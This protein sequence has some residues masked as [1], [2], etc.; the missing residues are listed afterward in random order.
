MVDDDIQK[1]IFNPARAGEMEKGFISTNIIPSGSG[2]NFSL[3]GLTKSNWFF[4]LGGNLE[5]EKSD[6]NDFEYF[7]DNSRTT[8]ENGERFETNYDRYRSKF[9]NKSDS[10]A[11]DITISKIFSTVSGW[12]YSVGLF[13][14]YL[15]WEYRRLR[16]N[17]NYSRESSYTERDTLFESRIREVY[18][19]GIDKRIQKDE[20]IVFGV[21]FSTFKSG[22]DS[23]HRI[24]VQKSDF[25]SSQE[26]FRSYQNHSFYSTNQQNSENS[27]LQLRTDS[28]LTNS[29]PIQFRYEGYF[30]KQVDWVG[31]TDYIFLSAN[32]IYSKG[33]QDF[34][35]LDSTIRT[36]SVDDSITQVT[37]DYG[38]LN[39]TGSL[40]RKPLNNIDDELKGG[41]LSLGYILSIEDNDL[42]FF[43]GINPYF[44][45]YQV[46]NARLGNE[47]LFDVDRNLYEWGARIPV[48]LSYSIKEFFSVWGGGNL[49]ATYTTNTMKELE[50]FQCPPIASCSSPSPSKR[51]SS[52]FRYSESLFMGFKLSHKSGLSLVNNFRS[53]LSNVNSWVTSLRYSF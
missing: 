1:V 23:K 17:Q 5:T 47:R 20:K 4:S 41:S 26:Y 30:N 11:G 34:Y 31:R 10:F 42:D 53:N 6:G 36:Y 46:S 39:A 2:D 13:A 18:S 52:S 21:E 7:E 43:T 24:Y 12:S 14:G 37:S 40:F 49:N 25:N 8:F 35:S 33:E 27:V 3:T 44:S 22:T 38:G 16:E 19:V 48:Y 32:A 50:R 51:T 15:I 28:S 45:A 29:N 9:E